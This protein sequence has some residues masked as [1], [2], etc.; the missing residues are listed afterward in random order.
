MADASQP[1]LGSFTEDTLLGGSVTLR[2][3][4]AGYRA[5]I[6]PLLLAAAVPAVS[7]ESVL[8]VGSGVGAAALCLARRVEGCRVA[9]LELQPSLVRLAG[10]NAELNGLAERVQFL[11]GDLMAPPPRLAPGTF[12]HVMTNPPYL[13]AGRANVSPV[14]GK[15]TA[16][17]ETTA[18]LAEWVRFCL[19][20]VKRKGSVTF[21]HRADRLD[22]LLAALA[23]GKGSEAAGEITVFP[24]W[25]RGDGQPAKRVILQAR[26]DVA[27]PLRLSPGLVLQGLDGDYTEAAQ[28]VLR[29]GAELGI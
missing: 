12:D 1:D 19:A 14:P 7:G 11:V 28:A 8:D 5:A 20:M 6:D 25:T 15:A 21:T 16:N 23:L 13:E 27:T 9:G 29:D 10:D 18:A 4:K 3:P 26:K 17:Q 24:L 22:A 2:Q